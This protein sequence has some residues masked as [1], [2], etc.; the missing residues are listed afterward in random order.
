MTPRTANPILA[1]AIS[2]TLVAPFLATAQSL[3]PSAKQAPLERSIFLADSGVYVGMLPP[4]G[5]YRAVDSTSLDFEPVVISSA[6]PLDPTLPGDAVLP[7]ETEVHD[8]L[9]DYKNGFFQKFALTGAWI[10]RN[11]SDSY[12]VTELDSFLTVALPAPTISWPLLITPG[13]TS[14]FIAG[15]DGVDLP[16]RVHDLYLQFLWAPRFTERI[17]LVLSSTSGIHSD[18]IHLDND[19][20]RTTGWGVVRFEYQPGVVQIL[21]GAAYLGRDDLQW[22]PLVGAI[23]D[24]SSQWHLELVAPRPKIARRIFT[25]DF[26]EYWVYVAGDFGGD[27]WS[28]NTP[29]GNERL[30][31]GDWRV[32]AGLE[33]K[34]GGGAG[35]KTEIGYVFDRSIELAGRDEIALRDTFLVRTGITF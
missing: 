1:L 33:C 13:Y 4:S 6:V 5:K 34:R 35:W 2:A 27:T 18:F 20:Y 9:S 10:Y 8:R 19:A 30:T 16:A 26:R 12:E 25:T 15:P 17:S 7:G 22:V 32:L 24:P 21:A 11:G 23:L 3:A 29:R 28:V 14:R 31:L